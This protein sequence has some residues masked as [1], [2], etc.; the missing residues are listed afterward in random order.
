ME[1][2]LESNTKKPTQFKGEVVK[3]LENYD[4]FHVETLPN[5]NN[6]SL[7]ESRNHLSTDNLCIGFVHCF[8]ISGNCS[9][10]VSRVNVNSGNLDNSGLV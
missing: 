3:P 2:D 7:L 5:E 4:N 10:N 6:F 9:L 8:I 1:C